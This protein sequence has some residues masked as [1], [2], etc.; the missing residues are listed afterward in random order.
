MEGFSDKIHPVRFTTVDLLAWNDG[1]ECRNLENSKLKSALKSE[2]NQIKDSD[3]RAPFSLAPVTPKYVPRKPG[4]L[5]RKYEAPTSGKNPIA[6][7]GMANTVLHN[8]KASS[9][10]EDFVS[11][12]SQILDFQAFFDLS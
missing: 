9:N 7:S 11:D 12:T 10:Y 4:S 1:S 6:V 2:G 5:F 3:Q 8:D